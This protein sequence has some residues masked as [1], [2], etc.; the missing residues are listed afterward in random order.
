[1]MPTFDADRDLTISR[2]IKAPRAAI[3]DA[4]ANPASFARWW[5]PEP[6]VCRVVEM[7]LSPGG[8]FI[9]RMSEDG[10]TFTPHLDACFVDVAEGERI[11]FTTLLNG[12]WRPADKPFIGMTAIITLKNHP[13]GTDYSS[14]A[15]HMDKAGRDSHDEMGFHDGWGTVVAQLAKLV[16]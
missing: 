4:W 7:D 16:E 11:V 10:E 3:W 6:L 1:M 14:T 13:Q 5:I 9:T 15:M 12:G 2:I 8:A